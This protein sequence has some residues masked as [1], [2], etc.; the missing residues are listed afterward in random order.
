MAYVPDQAIEDSHE[1][2]HSAFKLFVAY[3]RYRNGESGRAWP[4]VRTLQKKTGIHFSYIPEL[5][6]QLVER[7]WVRIAEGGSTILLKG[8]DAPRPVNNSVR[9]SR[10]EQCSD[11][12]NAGRS[13][14][15][16]PCSDESNMPCLDGQN[17][18]SDDRNAP[19]SDEPND[20]GRCS[21]NSRGCSDGS[22][23]TAIAN[24]EACHEPLHEPEAA[25]G[26][27]E[28]D[29]LRYLG[30]CA[31]YPSDPVKDLEQLRLLAAEFPGLSVVAELKR[32][33]DW[34]NDTRK[35]LKKPRLFLRRWMERAEQIRQREQANGATINAKHQGHRR[36]NT[37]AAKATA[38]EAIITGQK[39]RQRN[40]SFGSEPDQG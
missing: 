14:N 36:A 7:H 11:E 1:V 31:Y 35:V 20:T 27:V 32:A 28:R 33:S 34:L 23:G 24:K 6:R 12:P 17:S 3:C 16:N 8:F 26:E 29:W 39:F 38:S 37:E 9:P 10:Q 2:S 15:P 30:R 21:D 22:Q 25:A 40:R 19:R 18:R 5:R 4:S 13:G